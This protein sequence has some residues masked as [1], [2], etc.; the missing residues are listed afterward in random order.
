MIAPL[1]IPLCVEGT[2]GAGKS[3]TIRQIR[4]H[5][6]AR[7]W[8]VEVVEVFARANEHA[9]SLGFAGAVPMLA[10][11]DAHRAVVD[12]EAA[13]RDAGEVAL[14]ARLREEKARRGVLIQDRGW[15]TFHTHVFDG[16][17]PDEAWKRAHWARA[18]ETAP[19]TLF[20]HTRPEV[21]M[22]RR[23]GQ[24]DAVSGLPDEAAVRADWAKRLRQIA[25][26]PGLVLASVETF[27]DAIAD[28][29]TPALAH[30]FE[31]AGFDPAEVRSR[32]NAPPVDAARGQHWLDD[33]ASVDAALDRLDVAGA[34]V[35]EVGVGRGAVTRRILARG[36]R[37]VIGVEI[38]PAVVPDELRAQIDLRVAD[39]ATLHP[40]AL[41]DGAQDAAFVAAPPYDHLDTVLGWIDAG[42]PRAALMVPADREAELAGFERAARLD[43]D[44][45]TPPSRGAHLWMVK[46]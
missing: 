22:T 1:V 38:D 43:G 30:V 36:P 45:F 7:G 35:V 15:L 10:D 23:A 39:L 41:V 16:A 13:V 11:P 24:L 4:R 3:S 42:F 19:P 5:L 8:I 33:V 46:G 37:R 12:F 2:K 32:A 28:K 34:L 17:Y 31:R 29:A 44:A 21:T 9:R 20:I 14:R 6:E 18:I 40:A 27:E 25:E 26:H